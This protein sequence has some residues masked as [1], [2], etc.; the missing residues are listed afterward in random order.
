MLLWD[1]RDGAIRALSGTH[2]RELD[3]HEQPDGYLDDRDW[4]PA[5]VSKIGGVPCVIQAPEDLI[6]DCTE[7]NSPCTF[8]AQ[9]VGSEEIPLGDGALYI[10]VCPRGCEFRAKFQR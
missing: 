10:F 9:L 5:L 8:I 2:G 6:A 1:D 7:C 3:W 4:E